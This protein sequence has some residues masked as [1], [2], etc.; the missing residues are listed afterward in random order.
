MKIFQQ[1]EN[2]YSLLLTFAVIII[3]TILGLSLITLT[4]SGITKN[5][6]REELVQAQDLS[7]KGIDYAIKDIQAILKKRD[8]R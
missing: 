3:F 5:N 6:T 2:G 8:Y 4:S 1:N 7:D